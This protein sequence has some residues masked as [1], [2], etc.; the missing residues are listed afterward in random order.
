LKRVVA[1][2]FLWF[3]ST[4]SVSIPRRLL[5]R[6]RCAEGLSDILL[7]IDAGDLYALVLLDLSAAFDRVN[8]DILIR[9]LAT[10]Y[11]LSGVVPQWFQAYF[12][13]EDLCTWSPTSRGCHHL[14]QPPLRVGTDDVI[15]T[16]VARDLRKYIDCDVSVRSHVTKTV[17]AC[18]AVLRQLPSVRRSIPRSVLQSL[19]TS[20]FLT[21]LDHGNATLAGIPLYLLK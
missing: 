12:T 6:Y 18:F 21:R 7:V 15:P 14:L 5:D 20:L 10:S 4:A 19:V 16:A 13:E 17:S 9:R 8:H 11:G 3:A 2:Q 1:G